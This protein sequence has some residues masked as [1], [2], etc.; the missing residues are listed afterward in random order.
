[1]HPKEK[2]FYTTEHY[3]SDVS[4]LPIIYPYGMVT[5]NCCSDWYVDKTSGFGAVFDISAGVDSL[6]Y[7]NGAIYIIDKS[8]RTIDC[9][10]LNL[11]DSTKQVYKSYQE[12]RL[13]HQA[14]L[15]KAEEAHSFIKE[16]GR[17]PWNVY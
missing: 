14:Q 17:T 2:D 13:V 5:A 4:R 7:E 6:G 1:M 16:N 12:Y 3:Y 11:S 10:V 15:Y 9:Y 8:G